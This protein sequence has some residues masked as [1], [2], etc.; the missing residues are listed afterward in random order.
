MKQADLVLALYL[1]RRRVHGRAEGAR[2]RLLR[3]D[4]RARLVAVGVDPGD[5]RGRGRPPRPRATTTSPRR[6][7]S[8][9]T[10]SSTT[11]ATACTSRRSR[12]P[13][14]SR[15]PGSAGMRDHG[16]RLSFA[17]RLPRRLQRLAF[18]LVF[19]GRRLAVE[20][21]GAQA[22]YQLLDG[23]PL[24]SPTTARTS[25][26]RRSRSAA[27]SRR[28]RSARPPCQPPGREPRHRSHERRE[29]AVARALSH[30]HSLSG[31]AARRLRVHDVAG[32][33]LLV[34]DPRSDGAR[35]ALGRRGHVVDLDPA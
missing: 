21:T 4:H 23:E 12:A 3:G 10:T 16:G 6:R 24:E 15:S 35:Q 11:P 13:G 31:L 19:R 29:G 27:R 9:S 20:V 26:S 1:A 7:S 18:R 5:R 22:T 2:L 30:S 14:R 17:P 33:A 34:P 28:C 8:T 25:R 32:R